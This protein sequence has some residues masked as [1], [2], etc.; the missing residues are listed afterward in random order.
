MTVSEN[1]NVQ[2]SLEVKEKGKRRYRMKK[3][4]RQKDNER[5]TN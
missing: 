1:L 3:Y 5:L 4:E 2:N